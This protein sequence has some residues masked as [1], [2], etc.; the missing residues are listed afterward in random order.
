[1]QPINKLHS[2]MDIDILIMSAFT[3]E[4]PKFN[5]LDKDQIIEDKYDKFSYKFIKEYEA[6][7][8]PSEL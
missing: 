1:M 6:M 5:K 8:F 4:L 7:L 2:N 3:N